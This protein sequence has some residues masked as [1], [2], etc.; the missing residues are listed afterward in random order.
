LARRGGLAGL[1]TD[2]PDER[3]RLAFAVGALL[4][5]ACFVAGISF[6]YRWVFAL[7]LAPWLW[8]QPFIVRALLT[9]VVWMDG[10]FCFLVNTLVGPMELARL[11]RWE[12]VWGRF[13]QPLVWLLMAVLAG[14][15]LEAALAQWAELRRR[16]PA[17]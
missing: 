8:R 10:L 12:T 5:L 13:S 16:P 9:A 14:S 4:L 15:L 11:H 7:W 17:A 6:G 1:A 3:E 2:A